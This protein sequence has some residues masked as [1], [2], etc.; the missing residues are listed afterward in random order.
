MSKSSRLSYSVVV[1]LQL[2]SILS[3]M[4]KYE[5]DLSDS[6]VSLFRFI[7]IYQVDIIVTIIIVDWQDI[8]DIS[9]CMVEGQ[10]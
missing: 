4:Y 1:S 8:L 3:K 9:K 2:E 5:A 10:G 7:G 6:V